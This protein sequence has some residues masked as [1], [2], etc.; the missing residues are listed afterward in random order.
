MECS[1]ARLLQ[2]WVA[3]WQDLVDF[4]FVPV[5][6]SEETVEAITPML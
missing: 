2:T 1:E 6:P 3:Q 4:E 5:V